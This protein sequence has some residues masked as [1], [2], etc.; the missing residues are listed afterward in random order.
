MVRVPATWGQQRQKKEPTF[1]GKTARRRGVMSGGEW[2]LGRKR[3]GE[4]GLKEK[5]S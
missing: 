1:R 4:R 5:K 3:E 2:E